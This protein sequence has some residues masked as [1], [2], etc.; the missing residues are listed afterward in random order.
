MYNKCLP[1]LE[2]IK[3]HLDLNKLNRGGELQD[4]RYK[5]G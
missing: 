3:C 2:D 4:F 1:I 5:G